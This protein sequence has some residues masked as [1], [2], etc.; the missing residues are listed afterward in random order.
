[1]IDIEHINRLIEDNQTKDLAEYMKLHDL[2]LTDDNKI[3]KK[4]GSFYEEIEFW[5]KRQLVKK[6]LLN[7]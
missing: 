5:D 3:I 1:M 2:I 4:S 6:I 7:S